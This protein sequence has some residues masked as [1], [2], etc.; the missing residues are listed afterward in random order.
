MFSSGSLRPER[1]GL[2]SG[3]PAVPAIVLL[4]LLCPMLPWNAGAVDDTETPLGMLW[5]LPNPIPGDVTAPVT[6]LDLDGDGAVDLLAL[7]APE[8]LLLLNAS[9]GTIVTEIEIAGDITALIQVQ[10]LDGDG[11]VDLV[12]GAY[13][14]NDPDKTSTISLLGSRDWQPLWSHAPKTLVFAETGDWDWRGIRTWDL[15]GVEGSSP[16]VLAT[17]WKYLLALDGRTGEELYRFEAGNDLWRLVVVDDLTGDQRPEV[18]V[19]GQE[20]SLYLVDGATGGQLWSVTLTE[21]YEGD[22]N[23]G[24]RETITRSLWDLVPLSGISDQV[25]VSAEDGAVYLVDLADRKLMWKEQLV[26]PRKPESQTYFYDEDWFNHRLWG[27]RDDRLMAAIQDS[28]NKESYRLHLLD[29]TA[30][31]GDRQMSEVIPN[32][33]LTLRGFE[34]LAPVGTDRQMDLLVPLEISGDGNAF[35]RLDG[36]TGEWSPPFIANPLFGTPQ[37][38]LPLETQEGEEALLQVSGSSLALI[39]MADGEVIWDLLGG[40]DVEVVEADDRD[41]DGHPELLL[42]YKQD[43]WVRQAQLVDRVTGDLLWSMDTPLSTLETAGLS[44]LLLIPDQSGD[45]LLDLVALRGGG[46]V[47]RTRLVLFDLDSTTPVWEAPISEYETY[48]PGDPDRAIQAKLT[49][50]ELGPDLD[51]DGERD[52]LGTGPEGSIFIWGTDGTL[53]DHMSSAFPWA[54]EWDYLIRFDANSSRTWD[55]QPGPLHYRWESDRQGLLYQGPEGWFRSELEAGNHSVTLTVRDNATGLEDATGVTI[56]VRWPDNPQANIR[57]NTHHDVDHWQ[58]YLVATN[59]SLEFQAD[60]YWGDTGFNWT[61]ESQG[62]VLQR[63]DSDIEHINFS[64]PGR[65]YLNL[66]VTDKAGRHDTS[67]AIILARDE[68]GP[69]AAINTDHGGGYHIEVQ[70]DDQLWLDD[71]TDGGFNITNRTWRLDRGQGQVQIDHGQSLTINYTESGTYFIELEVVDNRSFRDV[72]QME[73]VVRA[74]GQPRA[75]IDEPHFWN[76]YQARWGHHLEGLP[77]NM[78]LLGVSGE[79]SLIT[80]DGQLMALDVDL[81]EE[82]R[83]QTEHGFDD[84]S[85][86]LVFDIDGDGVRDLALR[87]WRPDQPPFLV[88][89]N[90]DTGQELMTFPLQWEGDD[91]RRYDFLIEHLEEH[92]VDLDGDDKLDL[93][94]YVNMGE[95][96]LVEAYSGADGGPMW[97]P[98]RGKIIQDRTWDLTS[99]V[100]VVEDATGDGHPEVLLA[101][102]RNEGA[103]AELILLN[104]LTGREVR[105]VE[106][107]TQ[108]KADDWILVVPAKGLE[109]LGDMTGDGK[110]EYLVRRDSEWGEISQ[111]IDLEEGAV[112]RIYRSDMEIVSGPDL[113]G[114]GLAEL[115]YLTSRGLATLDSSLNLRI[116]TS[117]GKLSGDTLDLAWRSPSNDPVEILVDGVS[118]GWFEGTSASIKLAP[119]THKVRVEAAD[120]LG[121]R[122]SDEIEVEVEQNPWIT[123]FNYA[124]LTLVVLLALTRIIMPVIT[125]RRRS[126]ALKAR[127]TT[128]DEDEPSSSVP[129]ALEPSDPELYRKPAPPDRFGED[130]GSDEEIGPEDGE[131]DR[132]LEKETDEDEGGGED[133]EAAGGDERG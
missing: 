42:L 115:L 12:F 76:N 114:D 126:A 99:P 37:Q 87:E 111:I 127:R 26:L 11:L 78:K 121:G 117:G 60:N 71:V 20:G 113:N 86:R 48:S 103:G 73:V 85:V 33:T 34:A 61:L 5:V 14:E 28:E 57:L 100:L 49:G 25:A 4:C 16:M 131:P 109:S 77:W 40:L 65:Y 133:D 101:T 68:R 118:F 22:E 51:G 3:S 7:P 128:P 29:P 15:E 120:P 46:E 55:D 106:Y 110:A 52:L 83:Y 81:K 44:Q 32:A 63:L 130:E 35:G 91:D 36:S 17:S 50:L 69:R 96:T 93:V 19:G 45:G 124:M 82:W 13:D 90:G 92:L 72:T 108:A 89:I 95:P 8:L 98:N 30:K 38:M 43:D 1:R 80:G 58:R 119:G 107:E 54:W 105:R 21:S 62:Q 59:R 31:S 9:S 27:L 79:T 132:G 75:T 129:P 74:P 24:F 94:T 70:T 102:S 64:L 67:G 47:N 23:D 53:I 18:V 104:G 2:F 66:T 116:T 39:G 84:R 112:L 123:P 122:V 125:R 41:G 88:F 6:P 10:D 56:K 97:E